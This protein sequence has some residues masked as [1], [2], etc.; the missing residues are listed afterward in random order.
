[1]DI[2]VSH[3]QTQCKLIQIELIS[4][5]RESRTHKLLLCLGHEL[6]CDSNVR[7][8]RKSQHKHY[9]AYCIWRDSPFSHMSASRLVGWQPRTSI[10]VNGE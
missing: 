8:N 6:H 2:G 9:D 3:E 5:F 7:T 10:V 4:V 1:M